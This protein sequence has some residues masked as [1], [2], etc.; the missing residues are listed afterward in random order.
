MVA[1]WLGKGLFI[2]LLFGVATG[3][4]WGAACWG[5][6]DVAQ[7]ASAIAGASVVWWPAHFWREYRRD[8]PQG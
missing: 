5:L 6:G 7:A 4:C 1:G 2:A 8:R 3:A